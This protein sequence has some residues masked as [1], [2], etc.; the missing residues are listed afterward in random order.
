MIVIFNFNFNA[1][2]CCQSRNC[3][4]ETNEALSITAVKQIA[5]GQAT[6]SNSAS[7]ISKQKRK[8]ICPSSSYEIYCDA[9]SGAIKY[10]FFLEKKSDNP[11]HL[12][13]ALLAPIQLHLQPAVLDLKIGESTTPVFTIN[14]INDGSEYAVGV[15]AEN[16]A[17]FYSGMGVAAGVVGLVPT[18]PGGIGLR[19]K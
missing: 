9:V 3:E 12:F 4:T 18:K 16:I 7:A 13:E 15:V 5:V 1:C 19:K 14:L 6:E 2:Y 11:Y 10:I 17:G 8:S